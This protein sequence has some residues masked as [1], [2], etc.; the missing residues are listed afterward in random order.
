L[1]ASLP[2][3]LRRGQSDHKQFHTACPAQYPDA[4]AH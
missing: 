4:Q 1:T 3:F 2:W